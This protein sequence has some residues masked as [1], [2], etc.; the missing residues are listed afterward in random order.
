MASPEHTSDIDITRYRQYLFTQRRVS[1]WVNKTHP[2]AAPTHFSKLRKRSNVNSTGSRSLG[3][4]SGKASRKSKD[5]RSAS[6]I[7]HTL[8]TTPDIE[9]TTVPPVVALV[10]SSLV[11]WSL[12]LLPLILALC[13]FAWLLTL[14]TKTIN[15]RV[16]SIC[17]AFQISPRITASQQLE[18]KSSSV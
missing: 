1:E 4:R 5:Q 7:H 15:K 8:H 10:S 14:A 13:V 16:R 2:Q 12:D 11:V 9:M 18:E 3:R 17:S 6:R